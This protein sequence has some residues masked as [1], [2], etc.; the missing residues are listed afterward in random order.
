MGRVNSVTVPCDPVEIVSKS[1]AAHVQ[2]YDCQI[3][4]PPIA[5]STD[6]DIRFVS[7]GSSVSCHV[8]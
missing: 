8:G 5:R 3:I 1:Q 7:D 6:P 4:S 2:L